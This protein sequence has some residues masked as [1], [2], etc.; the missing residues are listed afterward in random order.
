MYVFMYVC[1]CVCLLL[2]TNDRSH[3]FECVYRIYR[4]IGIH[5]GST[6][7]RIHSVYVC[8]P[9]C[10]DVKSI[11]SF[12]SYSPARLLVCIFIFSSGFGFR[13]CSFLNEISPWKLQHKR[14]WKVIKIEIHLNI[15]TLQNEMEKFQRNLGHKF[16]SHFVFRSYE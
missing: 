12:I 16:G 2:R 13:S 8:L 10:Y 9:L 15:F 6:S 4:S 14:H 1:V 11:I 3:T 5:I 7:Q